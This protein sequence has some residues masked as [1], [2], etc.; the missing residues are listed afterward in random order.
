MAENQKI[1]TSFLTPEQAEGVKKATATVAGAKP[2][3]QPL[4]TTSTFLDAAANRLLE[5]SGIISSADTA[6]EKK[7]EGIKTGIEAGAEATAART[8][9]IF[10]REEAGLGERRAELRDILSTSGRGIGAATMVKRLEKFDKD[11]ETSLKDL[12][13][14]KSEALAIGDASTA[15]QLTQLELSSL[16]FQQEARQRTFQNLLATSQFGLS[17]K[18]EARQERVQSFAERSSLAGI[19]LEFG[20]EIK[21][22]DTLDSIVSRAAPFATEKRQAEMAAL[23]ASTRRANAEAL[24]AEQGIDFVL[25]DATA[26]QLAS[27]LN[28]LALSTDPFASESISAILGNIVDK[29]GASGLEVVKRKQLED[30]SERF[31]DENLRID[32]R[33][34][35]AAGQSR[36][37]ILGAITDSIIM[38]DEQQERA[39]KVLNELSPKEFLGQKTGVPAAD[40]GLAA[41]GGLESIGESVLHFFTGTRPEGFIK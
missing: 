20:I 4:G 13:Q 38:N 29:H 1:D 10:G 11:T 33:E 19:G 25:D 5:T 18:A 22:G 14:R 41:I 36:G 8:E 17:A 9:S 30:S 35:I 27:T 2:D 21:E 28:S 39:I 40:I 16:Q 23:A 32:I 6:L 3:A 34:D 24:K 31:T 37:T 15:Q 12:A 7:I 26:V